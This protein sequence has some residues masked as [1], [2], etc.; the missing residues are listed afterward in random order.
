MAA[1]GKGCRGV[2]AEVADG[3]CRKR[4]SKTTIPV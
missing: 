3:I 2:V 1:A 4:A